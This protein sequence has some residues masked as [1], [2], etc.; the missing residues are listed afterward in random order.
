MNQDKL[1]E[2]R[3]GQILNDIFDEKPVLLIGIGIR[4]KNRN[5]REEH[6]EGFLIDTFKKVPIKVTYMQ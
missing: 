4:D 3:I 5:R 6:K 2:E 1:L